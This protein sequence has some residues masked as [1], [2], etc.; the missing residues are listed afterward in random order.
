MMFNACRR[1]P[2]SISQA[3]RAASSTIR[4]PSTRPSILLLSSHTPAGPAVRARWL[5]VSSRLSSQAAAYR[6]AEGFVE[7]GGTQEFKEVSKFQEL[8]DQNMVHRNVVEEIIRGMGHHTMTEVQRMTINQG[9]QGTD[10]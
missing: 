3:F 10:M 1:G 7:D 5:H 2:A 6:D 8:I 4:I 9:L